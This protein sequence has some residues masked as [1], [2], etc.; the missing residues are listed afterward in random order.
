MDDIKLNLADIRVKIAA[1]AQKSGRTADEITL[2]GVTKT[3]DI[4]RIKIMRENGVTEFGENKVQEIL[5]KYES[6]SNEKVA[7][8]MIGHLQTNKVKQIIDKVTMIDS[9]DTI[10]LAEEIAKKACQI[11]KTMDVLLEINIAN[12]ESKYGIAPDCA[13]KFALEASAL[14]GIRIKG[15]MCVA[16][17][18]EKPEQNRGNFKLMKQLFI[19][20]QAKMHNNRTMSHLSMGMTNDYEVAIEEGATIVR[21]GTG[22]FGER[23]YQS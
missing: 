18:V 5:A 21:I 1:A 8:H 9:V 13:E 19:D 3:I 16:P 12:E 20:I 7:W 17:F 4:D 15:L 6:F 10:K 23:I 14:E 11:G 2:I 22:I